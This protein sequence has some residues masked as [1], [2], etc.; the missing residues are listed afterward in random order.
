MFAVGIVSIESELCKSMKCA[1]FNALYVDSS[2]FHCTVEFKVF[3][4]FRCINGVIPVEHRPG[5]KGYI[6]HHRHRH[7]LFFVSLY[8]I[9]LLH[10]YHSVAF[11]SNFSLHCCMSASFATQLEN[12]GK[13]MSFFYRKF[14]DCTTACSNRELYQ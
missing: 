9:P 10:K 13:F 11:T 8:V 12:F 2:I 1:F 7:C 4:L 6:I 5:N 14:N 3:Y